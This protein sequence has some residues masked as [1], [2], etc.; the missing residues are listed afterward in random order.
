[1]ENTN[2][3]HN[4]FLEKTKK[5]AKR[6]LKL[7]KSK[8]S[9]LKIESL[10]YAQDILAQIN[11]YPHWHAL[12]STINKNQKHFEKN[13]VLDIEKDKTN[14]HQGILEKIDGINYFNQ[15]NHIVSVFEINNIYTIEASVFINEI[16]YLKNKCSLQFNMGFHQVSLIISNRNKG[17]LQEQYNFNSLAELL[18]LDK[19]LLKKLFS[20]DEPIKKN[21]EFC[22]SA[23]IVVKTDSELSTEHADF[24]SNFNK[25]KSNILK[26]VSRDYLTR[27]ELSLINQEDKKLKERVIINNEYNLSFKNII[28]NFKSFD[29]QSN[30]EH[31]AWIHAI[32]LLHKKDFEWDLEVNLNEGSFIIYQLQENK[33]NH[34]YISGLYKSLNTSNNIEQPKMF[35]IINKSSE[36]G[37]K[38]GIPFIDYEDNSIFYYDKSSQLASYDNTLII[39]KPGSGKSLLMNLM[40]LYSIGNEISKIPY[41][42]FIDIGP[43]SKPLIDFLK[44]VLPKEE[45]HLVQYHKLKMT[46]DFCVNIFDTPL[47]CRFPDTSHKM[48]LANFISLLIMSDDNQKHESGVVELLMS[49]IKE[50]YIESSDEF[51]PKKYEKNVNILIDKALKKI[52]FEINNNTSWWN[53]VDSLFKNGYE[54]EA[55]LAQR[56][57]VPIMGDI[58]PILQSDKIKNIYGQAVTSNSENLIN[59]VIRIINDAFKDYKILSSITTF[60]IDSARVVSID[61]DDV[62]KMGGTQNQK[63]S[64]VM[65]M[66]AKHIISRKYK[67]NAESI[68]ETEKT[69]Y[70]KLI[71]DSVLSF[72][73]KFHEQKIHELMNLRKI[74]VLDE[75]HRVY[76]NAFFQKEIKSDLRENIRWNI[77]TVITTQ[78]LDNLDLFSIRDIKNLIKSIFIL[79]PISNQELNLLSESSKS[80]IL[81]NLELNM[82][83]QVHGPRKGKNSVLIAKILTHKGMIKKLLSF[84][85]NSYLQ[86][87]LSSTHE[88]SEIREKLLTEFSIEKTLDIMV[89]EFPNG[90]KAEISKE[91]KD[92]YPNNFLDIIFDELL[93]KYS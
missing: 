73:Q 81:E 64:C 9:N 72:Y 77:E 61:L 86:A 84:P 92:T 87:L 19:S 42:G 75:F 43:S 66:L 80:F 55:K 14:D 39:G 2:L 21:M 65:Y 67:E 26:I 89:T 25:H 46:K 54:Y 38:K 13:I 11:G 58:I 20:I 18:K 45:K 44:S 53:I 57:A 1:M 52:R 31:N 22:L 47:G 32:N 37:S 36:I 10:S 76:N 82:L 62:C 41:V 29:S 85:T 51:H 3:G 63:F 50:V 7:A 70:L 5:Q 78:S 34:T 79:D 17:I 16:E 6:L 23:L 40:S 90:V 59:Y 93:K 69:Q 28:K 4:A 74:I 15:N 91:F 60:D 27:E 83:S 33:S 35:K 24:C 68:T 8:D 12:E 88:D 30:L 56:Y 49:I 48:F 71:D